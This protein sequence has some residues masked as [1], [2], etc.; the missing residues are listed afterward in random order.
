MTL[1]SLRKLTVLLYLFYAVPTALFLAVNMPPYLNV[2]ESNQVMRAEMMTAG[3]WLGSRQG[4]LRSVASVDSGLLELLTAYWPL[5]DGTAAKT[6]HAMMEQGARVPWRGTRLTENLPN[7][8]AYPPTL[9][10][11]ISLGLGIGKLFNFPVQRSIVLARLLNAAAAI[12]LSALALWQIRRGRLVL[13]T[14]LLFPMCVAQMAAASQDALLLALAALFIA[15]LS[16]PLAA[17]RDATDRE[18]LVL[19]ALLLAM[20]LSRPP[21]LVFL[22]A[23]VPVAPRWWGRV[24]AASVAGAVAAITLAWVAY[25]ATFVQVPLIVE[26]GAPADALG[27][28]RHL[29]AHPLALPEAI[30][31][32]AFWPLWVATAGLISWADI[33]IILPE[34]F[35]QGA[36]LVLLLAMA[37]SALEAPASR[38]LAAVGLPAA[39][40]AGWIGIFIVQYMTFTPVGHGTVGG[41]QGRYFLPLAM[42]LGLAT[43]FA[44]APTAARFAPSLS[45]AI[46][47]LVL[48]FPV[49]MLALLP[50]SVLLRLFVG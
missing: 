48:A 26:G 41:V 6:T 1:P 43:P 4:A 37:A 28:L 50:R 47:V 15:L 19:A 18:F 34:P 35:Y 24:S 7:V 12:A 13:F 3:E 14:V 21:M 25:L 44:G 16:I 5:L 23:L 2:D 11:P 39:V 32:T 29:L 46:T 42:M 8:G 22:L 9:Y 45:R 20:T 10:V 36:A 27:Q 49:A 30:W 33:N 38:P 31:N 17:R 40:V